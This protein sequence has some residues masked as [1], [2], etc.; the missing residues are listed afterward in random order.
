MTLTRR[1][2]SAIAAITLALGLAGCSADEPGGTGTLQ[3]N[4]A[5]AAGVSFEVPDG[6]EPVDPA[7]IAEGSE[8]SA[9]LSD[10]AERL[11]LEPEQLQQQMAGVD[12]VVFSDETDN[13]N[14]RDNVNVTSPGGRVPGEDELISQ[15]ERFNATVEEV[16]E[17]DTGVGEALT[18][19]YTFPIAGGSVRGEVIVVE[20]DGDAVVITVSAFDAAT[21]AEIADTIRATLTA[22]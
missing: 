11:G 21:A 3:G 20:V 5:T 4:V 8:G 15:F 9:E 10:L 6:W 22:A 13:P 14:F 1:T 12:L 2:G 17:A 18:L 19:V 16:T 7:D